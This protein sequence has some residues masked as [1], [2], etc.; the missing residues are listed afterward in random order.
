MHDLTAGGWIS[1]PL[2]FLIFATILVVNIL[3]TPPS[4]RTSKRRRGSSRGRVR[5]NRGV[6][7]SKSHHHDGE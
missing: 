2:A 5:E 6:R 3:R 1:V 4:E 7:D